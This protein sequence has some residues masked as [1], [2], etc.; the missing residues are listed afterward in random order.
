MRLPAL[1]VALLLGCDPPPPGRAGEAAPA[2]S[3][4]AP[5]VAAAPVAVAPFL[6]RYDFEERVRRF[7]LPGRLDE[8]SGLAFTAD[9]RLFAHDDER[10]RVHQIDPL[11]GDVTKA[12]DLGA[13]LLRDDLEGI[14]VV[15]ERFFLVSSTGTLYEF[16]EGADG[17]DVTYRRTH[18][19]VAPGCEVEGL[20]WDPGRDELLIA[21][22]VFAAEAGSIVVYR[23]PVSPDRE[24]PPPLRVPKSDLAP[25]GLEADFDPSGVAVTPDGSWLLLSARHDALI[26]VDPRGSILAAVRLREGRHPQPEGLAI[27]P[28][29]LL[30]VADERNGDEP[31]LTAYGPR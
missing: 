5:A 14:A 4:V 24:R 8:I 19:G 1:F 13:D 22:K 7:E 2:S 21:C 18:S 20:D 31:R 3:E 9:G 16:R 10:G 27:G 15:G 6:E 25:F 17:E 29:G 28:D 26:E 30:W 12:F 23:L 11:T